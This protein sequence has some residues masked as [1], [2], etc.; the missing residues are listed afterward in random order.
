MAG[1]FLNSWRVGSH[2]VNQHSVEA[3]QLWVSSVTMLQKLAEHIQGCF[4]RADAAEQRAKEATSQI[5]RDELL[6]IAKSW[7]HLAHSYQF[8]ESL[9]R[10]IDDIG[11][12]KKSPPEPPAN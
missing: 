4:E 12:A 8:R 3:D 9:E 2:Y 1:L 10:F 5:A 7:R 11:R 6:D